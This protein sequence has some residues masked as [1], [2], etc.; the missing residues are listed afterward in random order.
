M[1]DLTNGSFRTREE[2]AGGGRQTT[3]VL[4]APQV[5]GGQQQQQRPPGSAAPGAPGN[6]ETSQ[7]PGSAAGAGGDA[8]GTAQGNIGNEDSQRSCPTCG[9]LPGRGQQNMLQYVDT[10]TNDQADAIM[11][12]IVAFLVACALPF[13]IVQNIYFVRL[14]QT[15]RPAFTAQNRLKSRTWC[16][17]T[18]L[19]RLFTKVSQQVQRIFDVYASH[20]YGRCW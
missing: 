12:A 10:M 1:N 5:G 14:L 6:A 16:A 2:N 20:S 7:P 17:T 11:D 15:L 19:E 9:A 4:Q 8:G 18:G 3:I 13:A